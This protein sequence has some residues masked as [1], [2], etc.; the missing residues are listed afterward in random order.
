MAFFCCAFAWLGFVFFSVQDWVGWGRPFL[1]VFHP[2]T[3]F[4]IYTFSHTGEG[5]TKK[6]LVREGWC[7]W[8]N[9]REKLGGRSGGG[10]VGLADGK[11]IRGWRSPEG[12]I[13]VEIVILGEGGS[14]RA[15]DFASKASRR[16]V[17]RFYR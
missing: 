7:G 4:Y 11:G 8:D 14:R 16:L 12:R 6:G 13:G 1:F 3:R 10:G 15:S 17:A 2:A 9:F 5:W